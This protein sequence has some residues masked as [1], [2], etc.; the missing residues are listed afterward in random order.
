M[1]NTNNVHGDYEKPGLEKSRLNRNKP[2]QVV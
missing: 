2:D 1:K